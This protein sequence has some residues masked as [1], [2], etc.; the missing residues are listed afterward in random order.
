MKQIL[1]DKARRSITRY[2][3]EFNNKMDIKVGD[4]GGAN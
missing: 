3:R 4:W 1:T 2:N